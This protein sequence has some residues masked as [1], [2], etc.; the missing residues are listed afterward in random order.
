MHQ[1]EDTG[2]WPPNMLFDISYAAQVLRAW[3]SKDFIQYAESQ[4]RDIYYPVLRGDMLDV[5]CASWEQ[6]ARDY[7]QRDIETAE[8]AHS[9]N[10][11]EE[12]LSPVGETT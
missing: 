4:T 8:H 6:S 2:K 7:N 5:V 10:K 12:W 3:G 9:R 11:V 1:P